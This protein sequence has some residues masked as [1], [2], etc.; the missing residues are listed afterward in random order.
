MGRGVDWDRI[1]DG[2]GV[3]VENRLSFRFTVEDNN[4]PASQRNLGG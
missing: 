4:M 3:S 1:V 2:K